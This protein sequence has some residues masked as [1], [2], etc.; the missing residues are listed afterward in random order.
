MGCAVDTDLGD[1]CADARMSSARITHLF[2]QRYINHENQTSSAAYEVSSEEDCRAC[3]LSIKVTISAPSAKQRDAERTGARP[4]RV[5]LPTADS[6]FVLYVNISVWR[7]RISRLAP[8]TARCT[9]YTRHQVL[10]F[11][12]A[13]Q[14]GPPASSA[15]LTAREQLAALVAAP[16]TT[17]TDSDT[18]S[19]RPR[20]KV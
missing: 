17:E 15:L 7:H 12:G 6:T 5:R 16:P 2:L 8:Q 11:N 4:R 14:S 18:T 3:R 13:K 1:A 20:T 9:L 10:M 19:R